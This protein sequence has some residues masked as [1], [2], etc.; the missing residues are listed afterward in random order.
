[1]DA[2]SHPM[3]ITMKK[4]HEDRQKNGRMSGEGSVAHE[5]AETSAF[6]KREDDESIDKKGM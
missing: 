6:E 2:Q 5:K 3:A 1:M 4:L